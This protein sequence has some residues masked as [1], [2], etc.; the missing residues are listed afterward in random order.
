MTGVVHVR[1][2][3]PLRLQPGVQGKWFFYPAPD[4][5]LLAIRWDIGA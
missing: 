2:W 3:P 1:P 4:G 5:R